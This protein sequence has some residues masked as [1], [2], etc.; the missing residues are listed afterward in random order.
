MIHELG[1]K[2]KSYIIPDS[3]ECINLN[4]N[5]SFMTGTW[6]SSYGVYH[7]FISKEIINILWRFWK[8]CIV[9]DSNYM[10]LMP[11]SCRWELKRLTI[12]D[13]K[14]YSVRLFY[15][16]WLGSHA[17]TIQCTRSCPAF[18]QEVVS[19]PRTNNNYRGHK[20]WHGI[21]SWFHVSIEAR[22]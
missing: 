8:W 9:R 12:F 11:C 21:H 17:L 5:T 6:G 18:L 15:N 14:Q 1:T 16:F 19:T 10:N 13:H 20:C 22:V 7:R 4:R 2:H 3:I